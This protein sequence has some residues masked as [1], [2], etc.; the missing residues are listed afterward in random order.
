MNSY[1]N[2]HIAN[3]RPVTLII[4]AV[5]NFDSKLAKLETGVLPIALK[6]DKWDSPHECIVAPAIRCIVS[7]LGVNIDSEDIVEFGRFVIVE[8]I[9]VGRR[10]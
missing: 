10:T 7:P 5:P 6:N 3:T 4:E 8:I 1:T 9:T 2:R